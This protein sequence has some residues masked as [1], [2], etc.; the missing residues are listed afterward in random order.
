MKLKPLD[1]QTIVITGGSSGIGLAT[2]RLAAERGARVV[3][4]A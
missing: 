4:I 3:I 1:Q 2:A